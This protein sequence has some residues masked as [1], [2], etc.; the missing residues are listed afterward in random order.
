MSLTRPVTGGHQALLHWV[1]MRFR[2]DPTNVPVLKNSTVTA[3]L[4][5]PSSSKCLATQFGELSIYQSAKADY[6]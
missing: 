1:A 4:V 2:N 3:K 6:F 5:A